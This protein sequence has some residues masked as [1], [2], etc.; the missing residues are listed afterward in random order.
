MPIIWKGLVAGFAGGLVGSWAMGQTHAIV[1]KLVG[2]KAA[3]QTQGED[4]TLRT[5]RALA[6][7][8][9]HRQLTTAEVKVAGPVVHYAFG[10]SV[11]AAY[12][13][14]VELSPEVARGAG[15]PF[16]TAVWLGAHVIIVPALGLSPAVTQSPVSAEV[17]EFTAHLAYG[18]ASEVVR[19]AIRRMLDG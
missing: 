15:L 11:A 10:S 18:A 1:T 5:A 4:S 14:A 3:R 6:E 2:K 17:A 19:R 7:P 8:I 13:A 16:G 12:G 9:L